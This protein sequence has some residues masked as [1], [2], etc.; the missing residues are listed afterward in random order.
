LIKTLRRKA[1][2][3]LEESG[4]VQLK[5]AR[6]IKLKEAINSAIEQLQV[7]LS[8]ELS[9]V[10][11]ASHVEGGWHITIEFIERVAVPDTL[12]LLGTYEIELDEYGDIISYERRSMRRRMDL[13]EMVE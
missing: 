12:D 3:V 9:R 13:E 10:I 4:S 11:A 5:E 8:L 1:M 2:A 7:F 6:P